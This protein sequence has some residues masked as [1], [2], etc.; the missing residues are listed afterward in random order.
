[1][2]SICGLTL[3]YID[4][5]GGLPPSMW[6]TVLA[7]VLAA[8]AALLAWL[9]IFG[10][11]LI[12]FFS[13]RRMV[14]FTVAAVGL[15][16]GLGM[17]FWWS[18]AGDDFSRE[19]A[20]AGAPRVLVLAFDGMDPQL[21]E[22]Y[23]RQGRLPN[24]S[25]LAAE[26][27]YHPLATSMAPQSPVAWCTFITGRDPGGH[28]VFDFIKRN[29]KN[30]QP[31]LS[32][33]DRHTMKLPWQGTGLWERPAIAQHGMVAQRLPMVFPPPKMHGCM[34]CG[35]GVWD[36]RGTEG[37]YFYY[38]T[39]P[40][41]TREARG[42]LFQF[43]RDGARLRGQLPGPYRVGSSD[44][45]R[46]P[47]ELHVQGEQATFDLQG[48]QHRLR[49]GQWSDWIEVEFGL[50][51]L[52]LQKVRAVTRVLA[53]WDG[54]RVSLYVSPLNF[55]PRSPLYPISHPGKYS[56]QLAKAI[57][58]YAT[59]GM[60]YDT[61]AVNDGILSDDDF[62]QQV[63]QI[64]DESERML[65]HELSRFRAGVL[66]AYFEASD[67]VQH[68]FWRGID[69][70]HPLHDDP[71]TKAHRDA[72]PQL[73][74][75]FDAI[76]GRSRAALGAGGQVVVMSDHGFAPF[77]HSVHLNTLL[78]QLGYLNFTDGK[79]TS[80]EL[81]RDVDWSKTKAY[82]LGFNAVYL[83]K[84][85]REAQGIVAEAEASSVVRAIAADLDKWQDPKTGLR[86]IK[87]AYVAAELYS[88][89][90]HRDA[91]DLVVGYARD[92]RASWNTALG[93]APAEVL[94]PNRK[95]WSGDHCIDA[96][97][98]PGIYLSSDARLDAASLADLGAA[99][100]KYL[101]ELSA[102]EKK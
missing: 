25:R 52:G 15:G 95:K 58:L 102:A 81:L 43:N 33:A 53:H 31:D 86:P 12:G 24:F 100:D 11:R 26:G 16:T 44:N 67:I 57:G 6:G 30:Y 66:F 19:A 28:G 69:P 62:L 21:L 2:T 17:A 39:E 96:A 93:A 41:D 78:H 42:M 8:L 64:T 75:Q 85:G 50:G 72:I 94:E 84:A 59:R 97:E 56:A 80:D 61:Q 48:K 101:A 13:L 91:P 27:L 71:E 34:L 32:L 99:L 65:F 82:A 49:S 70:K 74:E 83:N 92:F 36:V 46:E 29:P 54:S 51:P 90:A 7:M 9:R 38:D 22:Q 20:A 73:Y 14:I 98:V 87:K 76:L 63:R 79:T 77:R 10:S 89:V 68:M 5:T 60:P 23:M 3:A 55:D 35:M 45:V 88:S 1:M 37:T 40:V 4:P 18:R 47:L